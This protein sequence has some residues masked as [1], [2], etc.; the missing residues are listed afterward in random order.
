MLIENGGR[1]VYHLMNERLLSELVKGQDEERMCR[2]E[3]V[4]IVC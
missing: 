3:M 1:T 2:E 4:V